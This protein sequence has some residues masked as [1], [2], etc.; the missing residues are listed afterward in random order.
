MFETMTKKNESKFYMSK[1]LKGAAYVAVGAV[2]GVTGTM[3]IA[4]VSETINNTIITEVEVEKIVEIEVIKE[5]QVNVTKEVIVESGNL[6]VV[7]AHLVDNEGDIGYLN[8]DNLDDD[9]LDEVVDRI[10]FVDSIKT[11]AVTAI[12]NELFEELDRETF[13]FG[14]L[15]VRFDED[16]LERLRL[17]DDSDEISVSNID[18]D[19]GDAKVTVTGS[20]RYD[21]D[22]DV[23]NDVYNFTAVVEFE[24]GVFEDFDSIT[25]TKKN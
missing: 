5:V 16:E 7:L 18:F 11:G 4:P 3:Y 14:N 24:D 6:N 23:E 22:E 15:S 21:S 12:E 1:V 19:D 10:I 9:E 17:D 13:T 20:F 2:L 25:I 8:I